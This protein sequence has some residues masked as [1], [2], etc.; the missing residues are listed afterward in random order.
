MGRTLLGIDLDESPF[1]GLVERLLDE[2]DLERLDARPDGGTG[3]DDAPG[4]SGP[5]T[6]GDGTR[7]DRSPAWAD[8]DRTDTPSPGDPGDGSDDGRGVDDTPGDSSR[9]PSLDPGSGDDDG[10]WRA[11]LAALGSRLRPVLLAAVGLVVLGGVV[12]LLVRRY[13]DRVAAV[14]A[15][16][17]RRGGN[18]ETEADGDTSRTGGGEDGWSPDS[19][20]EDSGTSDDDGGVAVAP[21]DDAGALVALAFLALVAALARKVT[22][23]RPRDPLADGPE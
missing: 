16:R 2:E 10:D 3:G 11:R 13:G 8:H 5:R 14:L 9:I 17:L 12:V 21:D 18:G 22:E 19:R 7:D 23:D 15:G 6:G 20:D 4:G 1:G